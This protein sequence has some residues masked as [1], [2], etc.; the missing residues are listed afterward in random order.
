MLLLIFSLSFFGLVLRAILK[1]FKGT[2]PL[3]LP[4]GPWKLPIIGNM[5]NI[6]GDLPHRKLGDLAK[7]YGPIMQLRIGQVPTFVISS[8]ETATQALKTHDI[9]FA[10]RPSLIVSDIIFYKAADIAFARYGDHWRQM[11]KLCILELLSPKRVQLFRPVREEEVSNLIARISSSAGS[12][13]N[14]TKMLTLLSCTLISRA[15]FGKKCTVQKQFIPLSTKVIDQIVGFNFADLFPSVKFLDFITGNRYRLNKLHKQIDVVLNTIIDEHKNFR[16]SSTIETEDEDLVHV[17]LNLQE[18][19]KLEIPLTTDIIKAVILDMFLAA[20]DSSAV[21][22]EWA[23][24]ELIKNPKLMQ[25][26]QA[27]VR[28]VFG[29]K[30]IVEETEFDKLKY[31][32]LVIKETMRVHP[33]GP[34]LPPRETNDHVQI[35]GYDIP[36]KSRVLVNVWA[37]GTD[38]KYWIEPEKFLPERFSDGRVD[39]RG[40]NFELLPF[41]AG[42]RV[43][44]G[45]SFAMANVE[46]VLAQL[47]FNFDW[48]LPDGIDKEQ[49]DMTEKFRTSTVRKYDLC[50]IPIPRHV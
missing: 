2:K 19:G 27:E 12:V 23:M 39:F 10:Q 7:K 17:L 9:I 13:V 15:A 49:L 45:I 33:A 18:H 21:T 8:A 40:N 43:C 46:L 5:H 22:V 37:I 48:D 4:P 26:A 31:L 44:P 30:G 3:N 20:V 36:A 16:A 29:E 41:G 42:R 47:L 25:K 1:K 14:L 6:M 24:S 11:R 34:L 35:N 32:K 38:P 28:Q 50:V